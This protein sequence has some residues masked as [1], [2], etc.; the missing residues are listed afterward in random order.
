MSEKLSIVACIPAVNEEKKIARVVL[1]AQKY[2]DRVIVCNDGSFDLTGEIATRLGAE[3]ITHKSNIGYGGSLRSLFTR[4]RELNA[5]I[6]VTLDGDGQ[7]NPDEIP[8]LVE[9]LLDGKADIVIGS[10]FLD[11]K[12]ANN[13]PS[14]RRKGIKLITNM[15]KAVSFNNITDAQSGYRAYN[16]KALS[17]I[18]P[19]E[20]GMG[21]STEIL[22]K[23][24]E[25]ALNIVE[26]PVF[27]NY[28]KESNTHAPLIHALDV[29][30]SV[31]KHLSIKRPLFF[32]GLPGV[33]AITFAMGFWVW[34]LQVFTL[35]RELPIGVTLVAVFMTVAGLVLL[36]T[37]VLLWVLISV[38]REK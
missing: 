30:L 35:T 2:V 31:V 38:F 9:P 17:V 28:D 1:S 5:D 29:I 3:V 23:A 12:S 18:D 34:V 26:V 36:T 32:Y 13:I 8:K 27:I 21:A 22:L 33:L 11:E 25:H 4:A 20:Y 14:Y 7:H 6:M 24:K 15:A 19:A 37:S 10:R 16:N